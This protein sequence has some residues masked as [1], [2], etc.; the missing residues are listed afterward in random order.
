MI[1]DL[2][3][4]DSQWHSLL[5]QRCDPKIIEKLTSFLNQETDIYPPR[6]HFFRSLNLVPY[7]QVKVLIM[8]QDPYHG[9]KEANGLAFAVHQ[10]IKIPPSLRNIF[11]EISSD[12][13]I[14]PP[15][16]TSLLGWAK[17]GVLLLNATLS[18]RKDQPR[19][20]FNQGWEHIT[21]TIIQILGE[22]EEPLVFMLWGKDAQE[23]EKF[24]QNKKHLILKTTH[25]SPLSSYRG[26]L[27][28]KHFSKANEFLS[29]FQKN[30]DWQLTE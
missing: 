29:S 6:E 13:E 7:S 3:T 23:K 17:Q 16:Q 5:S 18:V 20:H 22:R 21:N 4:K 8:G 2:L 24:I 19:S 1:L 11:K 28:C 30:I 25:P 9:E 14:P 27:G 12:L 26:F 15:T 10:G